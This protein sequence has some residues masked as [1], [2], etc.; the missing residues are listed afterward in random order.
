[1]SI[2]AGRDVGLGQLL[3]TDNFVGVSP[4]PVL[5]QN[6][7]A[8]R[9][10]LRRK[11]PCVEKAKEEPHKRHWRHDCQGAEI[12]GQGTKDNR[13]VRAGVLQGVL[14]TCERV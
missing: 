5:A 2:N 8:V 4:F 12:R 11:A 10:G 7:H 14:V 13:A 6:M 1:M 9:S 3:A